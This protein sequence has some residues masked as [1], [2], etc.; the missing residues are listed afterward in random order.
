MRDAPLFR[1]LL[2]DF[3]N[4]FGQFDVR[5]REKKKED[6]DEPNS[7]VSKCADNKIDDKAYFNFLRGSSNCEPT[8]TILS[9]AT[10]IFVCSSTSPKR[11]LT[12]LTLPKLCAGFLPSIRPLAQKKKKVKAPVIF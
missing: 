5:N 1:L 6:G 4:R 9:W 2:K 7:G 11:T 3:G 8:F 12:E 10:P